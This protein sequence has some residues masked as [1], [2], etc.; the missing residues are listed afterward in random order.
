MMSGFNRYICVA[1]FDGVET[2]FLWESGD[3]RPDSVVIDDAGFVLTFPSASAA[4][5]TL[6]AS[7]CA[8]EVSNYDL[9]AIQAW[10]TSR[11]EVVDCNALLNA[12]N[13]LG[14]L[15][16]VGDLSI[17]AAARTNVI[18]DKLFRGCN[19]PAMTPPDETFVPSWQSSEIATL[20][21]LLLLGLAELRARLPVARDR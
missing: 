16:N 18:Y 5:E 17:A 4:A 12:W 6:G 15:P 11:S 10:C 1:Q 14:D 19:L 3:N 21:R 13:L 2:A 8:N 20:K 7:L 9:D